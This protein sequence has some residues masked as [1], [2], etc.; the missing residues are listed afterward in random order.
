MIDTKQIFIHAGNGGKGAIS[1]IHAKFKP[2]GGPDGGDGGWG[3]NVYIVARKGI[4]TLGHLGKTYRFAAD[5]GKAGGSRDSTGKKGKDKVIEVPLG[6]VVYRVKEDEEREQL[7]DFVVPG[8]RAV[9]ARGGAPGRGNHRFATATNQEPLFAEVGERGEEGEISLEVKILGDVALVGAPNAGKSTL[10]S[11]ISRAKPKIADYPF[12][13]TTPVL[14]VVQYKGREVVFVDVPG[15]IEGA[16]RGRGLG[17][18]FLRH[19][20][21]VQVIVH[22]ID[23]SVERIDEEYERITAE[24]TAYPGNLDEKPKLVAINKIDIPEVQAALKRKTEELE[25]ASGQEPLVISGVSMEGIPEFLDHIL[26]LVP[27][28]EDIESDVRPVAEVK[29][30]PIIRERVIIER[31]E[32][33]YIVRCKQAE[34]FAPT[35]NFSNWRARLQFHAE[36]ERLGVIVALEK[37]GI[38]SGDMVRIANKELE[39]D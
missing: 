33:V 16:H 19:I 28:K 37:A 5:D 24:L 36:L 22:L 34:R 23:G 11:A 31:D 26:M 30:K 17:L 32:D 6:T 39:W 35:V 29:S 9:I 1:F 8:A 7:F 38:N 21:R 13:T 2:K 15:L 27:E 12:T 10:L 20:E 18:D 25:E 3:G 4:S 14:G